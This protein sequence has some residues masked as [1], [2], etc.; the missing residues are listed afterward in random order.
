MAWGRRRRRLGGRTA[1]EPVGSVDLPASFRAIRETGR[2]ADTYRA[3]FSSWEA[4]VDYC[5]RIVPCAGTQ[6]YNGLAAG[7]ARAE[8]HAVKGFYGDGAETFDDAIALARAGWPDGAARIRAFADPIMSRV[9][10]IIERD[11][12]VWDREGV[13]FDVA[14]VLSGDPD[15]WLRH[16]THLAA[17]P[18][19]RIIKVVVSGAFSW[20]VPAANIQ[21][22]GAAICALAECL[23]VAGYAAEIELVNDCGTSCDSTGRHHQIRATLKRPDQPLDMPALAVALTHPLAH[24]RLYFTT[25]EQSAFVSGWSRT[26]YGRPS[27]PTDDRGDVFLPTMIGNPPEWSSDGRAR[28]WVVDQLKAQGVSV[29]DE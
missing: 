8:D 12:Y 18:G 22:R 25:L 5:A 13:D 9:T 1:P 20:T 26:G 2:Q 6:T 23:D 11:E 28:E 19:R 24:R 4:L 3:D 7:H 29:R 14:A 27:N 15:H 16:E 17:G 10:S 21:R